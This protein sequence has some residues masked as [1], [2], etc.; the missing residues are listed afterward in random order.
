M[1]GRVFQVRENTFDSF[2]ADCFSKSE[3]FGFFPVRADIVG[4]FVPLAADGRRWHELCEP[5]FT[6]FLW[7]EFFR[8]PV[9][10]NNELAGFDLVA[11]TDIFPDD[12]FMVLR[13]NHLLLHPGF[14]TGF[15][16]VEADVPILYCGIK[17]YRNLRRSKLYDAPPD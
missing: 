11:L 1:L 8:F 10:N 5:D 3:I 4:P 9:F 7:L 15:Q 14:A 17:L 16:N 6:R 2:I 12:V 13:P